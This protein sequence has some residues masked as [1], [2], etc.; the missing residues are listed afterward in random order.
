M[1]AA[2][3]S[4]MRQVVRCAIYIRT[5][6]AG[7]QGLKDSAIAQEERAFAYIGR[8]KAA[9]WRLVEK[10]YVDEGFLDLGRCEALRGLWRD[11]RAG[12]L[13][14]VV[15][16]SYVRI[17]RNRKDLADLALV[18]EMMD[19]GLVC[20]REGIDTTTE[21]GR[22]F[23]SALSIITN[24][25][26]KSL[27]P[28]LDATIQRKINSGAW[29]G[30]NM[31]PFGY[32]TRDG[33]LLIKED[34]AKIVRRMY[35]RYMVLKDRARLL[36]ELRSSVDCIRY[37]RWKYEYV[38]S[39]LTNPVYAGLMPD[40]QRGVLLKGIHERIVPIGDY[41][42]VCGIWRRENDE[43]KPESQIGVLNGQVY[44]AGCGGHMQYVR[45]KRGNRYYCAN[46]K[47]H[48][49]VR[50][51]TNIVTERDVNNLVMHELVRFISRTETL[52]ALTPSDRM[53]RRFYGIALDNP[54][55]FAEMLTQ[56]ELRALCHLLVRRVY[57]HPDGAE[58]RFVNL[59]ARP[60]ERVRDLVAFQRSEMHQD[61]IQFARG[62]DGRMVTAVPTLPDAILS[63]SKGW[64]W[65]EGFMDG[66]YGLL[67]D[68]TNKLGWRKREVKD[69]ISIFLLAPP[70]VDAIIK[71]RIRMPIAHLVAIANQ[72]DWE[73]QMKMF[74]RWPGGFTSLSPDH[75]VDVELAY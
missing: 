75:E 60:D 25:E 10:R 9:G 52:K 21:T 74:N 26:H 62:L 63:L 33:V 3:S 68:L 44:C 1:D 5:T 34:E 8:K 16:D 59:E 49:Y 19:V 54:E 50:G 65:L 6:Y 4:K 22:M 72:I 51:I 67:K 35:R 45:D 27:S 14:V 12:V 23:A 42:R 43:I 15:V 53:K 30:S 58:I 39:I 13:D 66:R 37:E 38:H 64:R 28:K 40:K 11:V 36:T 31:S 24:A 47:G 55:R 29:L 46:L 57:V 48:P 2:E 73:E 56:E 20:V 7:I 17:A 71:R 70:I 61:G 32:V 41:R 18:L 69:A